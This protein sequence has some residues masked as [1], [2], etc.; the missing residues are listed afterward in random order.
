MTTDRKRAINILIPSIGIIKAIPQRGTWT[1]DGHPDCNLRAACLI[2]FKQRIA[3]EVRRM[4]AGDR[5]GLGSVTSKVICG[6]RVIRSIHADSFSYT[7]DGRRTLTV[8]NEIIRRLVNRID[9]AIK[10]MLAG[11]ATPAA[12]RIT[13]SDLED[14]VA[15][16]CSYIWLAGSNQWA[17]GCQEDARV[18]LEETG[19]SG[20]IDEKLHNMLITSNHYRNSLAKHI[21]ETVADEQVYLDNVSNQTITTKEHAMNNTKQNSKSTDKKTSMK[22]ATKAAKVEAVKPVLRKLP[23]SKPASRIVIKPAAL[24]WTKTSPKEMRMAIE[25]A[26]KAFIAKAQALIVASR[27]KVNVEQ[28]KKCA[29]KDYNYFQTHD[30]TEANVKRFIYLVSTSGALLVK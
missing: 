9:A 29:A 12:H 24:D 23:A 1:L 28:F 26:S 7:V 2:E 21:A 6:F 17:C 3:D 10:S 13:F 18:Y 11:Q 25:V 16:G 14:A 15:A 19:Y 5:Q 20:D 8:V 4:S 22:K 30:V 27:G